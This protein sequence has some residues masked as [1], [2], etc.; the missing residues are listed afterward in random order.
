MQK[1]SQF[2]AAYFI[3]VGGIGMS[4]LARWLLAQ[5]LVV[6]GYD[7]TPTPLTQQLEQEGISIHFQDDTTQIPEMFLDKT[8]CLVVYT[9]AVPSTHGELTF[10]LERGFVVV[11]RAELLG[12]ISRDKFTVAIAGTHGKT[13]TTAMVAHLLK[14][15]GLRVTAFLGGISTNY[16]SNLILSEDPEKEVIVVEADEFDRS[17]LNLKPSMA[18]ITSTDSDHLDIYQTKENLLQ[19]YQ[20]FA[21]LVKNPSSLWVN[22]KAEIDKTNALVYGFENSQIQIFD[23]SYHN[24][25]FKF[26]IRSP[27]WVLQD[28]SLP[29]PGFHNAEN[30]TAAVAV[31]KGLGVSDEAIR[32]GVSSFRGIKRRF[33]F[34]YRSEK[35]TYIDDYAHH[36]SEIEA[37]IKSV[38]LLFPNKKLTV[39][40]QPHLF[41]RTRDFM[42]GFAKSLA[43][44][45]QVLLL[46]IYPAREQPIEG[47]NSAALFAK[48]PLKTKLLLRDED[49]ISHLASIELEVLAT[50]GAGDID[51]FVPR[52]ENLLKTR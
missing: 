41:S 18:V 52:I 30:C 19:A 37:F 47:I 32:L 13:T 6:A 34:I 46:E 24:N 2:K 11:K 25:N 31:A 26:S 50:V 35:L 28:L 40:F 43:L 8:S 42:E 10:F 44:A 1:I 17:F 12:W 22:Q 23:L 39:V 27:D 5:G 16:Q 51:R 38:R 21:N 7:K 4:A 3:G 9:P 29:M 49:L 20:T 48:I 14:C 15:A 36:P 45:D 33:E